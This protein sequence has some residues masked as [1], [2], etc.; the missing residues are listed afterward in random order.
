MIRKCL[1]ILAVPLL[2][3][4][5][6]LGLLGLMESARP[7]ALQIAMAAP[8][9]VTPTVTLVDPASAPN[10]LDTPIVITGTDFVAVLSG[11]DVI[12]P[13][14]VYMGDIEL[15]EVGWVST[16]TLTATVPWGLDPG[17]YTVTVVNP[18]GEA[19][20]LG[21]A[22]T[23][24]QAIGVWTT[25]GPYG[26]MVGDIEINP[27]T[28]TI[29][30][31]TAKDAGVFRSEDGGASWELVLYGSGPNFLRLARPTPKV[32]YVSFWGEAYRS[33]DGGDT[34][35]QMQQPEWAGK[36]RVDLFRLFPHPTVS[37]VVYGAL[38]APVDVPD[39]D[40]GL[41]RSDDY[42]ETW[43]AVMNGLTDTMVTAVGFAPSDPSVMY[44]GTNSG[45][46]FRSTNGGGAWEFIGRPDDYISDVVVDPFDAD[47]VWACGAGDEG[48]GGY[49]WK[50][51]ASVGDWGQVIPGSGPQQDDGSAILFDPNEAG[52]VWVG[53][54]GGGFKSLD[55][56]ETWEV[57]SGTDGQVFALAMDPTNS[58]VVYQGYW[59]PG[60]YR[61]TDGGAT[62]EEMN[63][64][65]TGLIPRGLA[66][67]PGVP[68]KV[69]AGIPGMGV[70]QTDDGGESWRRLSVP[71]EGAKVIV[72][73][74]FTPTRVYVVE[75]SRI[76]ILKRGS[77]DWEEVY[78]PPP[79]KYSELAIAEGALIADPERPGHLLY[80]VGF[81]D[82]QQAAYDLL[83]GGFYTSTDYG[84]S[85][86][87]VDVGQE[88]SP[89]VSL[90]YD[91]SNPAVIYA[92]TG[93][94]DKGTG[95]WKSTD[96]GAT[97]I[98]L[99]FEGMGVQGIAVDPDNTQRIYAVADGR[100]FMSSDGGQTWAGPTEEMHGAEWLL[101]VL[102]DPPALYAYAWDGMKRTYDGGITWERAAGALGYTYI[103]AMAATRTDDRVVIYVGTG[104]GMVRGAGAQLAGRT[105]EVIVTAGVYRYTMRLLDRRVYLPVVLRGYLP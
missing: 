104:G 103:G 14:A 26:G 80:G 19:G 2:S 101:F 17:V 73:D 10:D 9:Q 37:G 55:G 83:V 20:R 91:P 13:P 7:D 11:T 27:I 21:D 87:Y 79:A 96:G 15:E 12:T 30:Y 8:L 25:G 82:P 102:S 46:I 98:Q 78:I 68:E 47:G 6:L 93:A 32:V 77:G 94:G 54:L 50:Y 42:G 33:D 18:G 41:F 58:Q 38:S 16:E 52:V 23:V 92:G 44:V 65:V 31:A 69:Y 88:I 43:V 62:W 5:A 34:W 97:W 36:G 100:F 72:F 84:R 45:N 35:V 3:M 70:Y 66:I 86:H 56:G 90:A 59:G 53:T 40:G 63:E 99:G 95:M 75:G 39:A 76:F 60:V 29:L 49:L 74:P 71:A 24:T 57:A 67:V 81:V 4:T 89:V 61:T 51:D 105:D 28:P 85:W 1:M 48:I 64:G 22:F